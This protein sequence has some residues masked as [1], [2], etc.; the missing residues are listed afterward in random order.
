MIK[1]SVDSAE[2]IILSCCATHTGTTKFSFNPSVL[3]LPSPAVHKSASDPGPCFAIPC[4]LRC[5]IG[6]K[7][8]H[9]QCHNS[10][11]RKGPP[12][13]SKTSKGASRSP[14]IVKQWRKELLLE[15]PAMICCPALYQ[16]MGF[17]LVALLSGF[18]THKP[19]HSS[20]AAATS[21]LLS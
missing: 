18:P 19:T 2:I 14:E 3:Y 10:H 1:L 20:T 21:L 4:V 15:S 6:I 8:L 9:G 5:V 12:S 16:S 17:S 7:P 11:T 13:L